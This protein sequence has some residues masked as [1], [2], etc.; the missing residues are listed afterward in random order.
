MR[1]QTNAPGPPG[2]EP[3]W[4]SSVKTGVGTTATNQS[5]VWFTIAQGIITE[6]YYPNI[7]QANTRD[8]QFMVS[9][10]TSFF[11]EEKKD[12]LSRINWL[13]QGVPC[14]NIINTC[15]QGRYRIEKTILTDPQRDVVLQ[16]I[17]FEPLKGLLSDYNVY[18]LLAPHLENHG[19]GNNGWIGEYK[20]LP[21]LFAQRGNT[22]LA[23]AADHPFKAMSCGYVGVSDG[24]QDVHAHKQ[25]KWFYSHA[26]NGNIALSGQI[27][28][29]ASNGEVVIALAFGHTFTEAGQRARIALLQNFDEVVAQYTEEWKRIQSQFLNLGKPNHAGIDVYRVS[30]AVLKTHEAKRFPGGLIASLSIPWGYIRGDD[31]LGGY[32]IVWPRDL[33]ESAGALLAAGD[34]VGARQTLIYL[35]STQEATGRWPQN[36][37]LD[38]RPYWGGIQ[39]DETAF[40]ILLADALRSRNNLQDL[41]PWPMIRKAAS[42]LVRNGPVTQQDRWEEDG[43]YSPFT[44]SAE[45]AALLAAAG[46][47]EQHG[48]SNIATYLRQT[49]D[50][51]NDSIERWTYVTNTPLAKK[52]GVQGYYVRITPPDVADTT[53]PRKGYVP[54]KNR[55]PD[56]MN[57]PMTQIVSPGALSLV[58]FGLR[59]AND[60]RIL[61][62][63]KV[64]D[65]LL[66][67]KTKTGPVW[68]RYNQ[69]GYG[70]HK[71]GTPF[72]GTG[73]GR[74]WPLLA[75]ERAHYELAVGNTTEARRLQEVIE[76][77][78]SEGGLIPEQV[79][80]STDIPHYD[81]QN[82]HPSGSAMPLVWAHAEYIK[83]L[84]S[85]HDGRVFDTPETVVRRYQ[86][87]TI[88]SDHRFWRFN[89]KVHSIPQGKILRIESLNPAKVHWSP[90][91]WRTTNDVDMIDTSLG[92]YYA[93]LP[94]ENLSTGTKVIFTFYWTQSNH[95][96][97]TD[98][99]VIIE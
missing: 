34:H 22:A 97:H 78:T 83:L 69:D 91:E 55:P 62:T 27:N 16:K 67:T 35:M 39:M 43:G 5:R 57:A 76:S 40:P 37:W 23:L 56:Q 60:T 75:G 71:D 25:M 74:G 2:F 12:T 82:G 42:F 92:V 52:I 94:T 21:M 8:M 63:V 59:A 89:H 50:I 3:C 1:K 85:L 31:D 29:I 28:L 33:V 77:Q 98:Y 88:I 58:R 49:A 41:K 38:G 79:W 45:I 36:M 44:L 4:T 66:K 14:Y 65:A 53:T 20:G 13:H 84:R 18:I 54:I 95:W 11:S 68:H 17:R 90:D 9:D 10:G 6:V 81:L 93:D 64:I 70:E 15:K 19:Y 26:P 32:H 72:N 46:F 96:E 87:D 24:W 47:A 99:T 86:K 48:E 51:W 61:N 7:D 73:T 30:T 80:D